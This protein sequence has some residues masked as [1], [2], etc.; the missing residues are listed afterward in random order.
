MTFNEMLQDI[1]NKDYE[2]IV[3]LAKSAMANISENLKGSVDDDGIATLIYGALGATMVVDG[4]FSSL[5]QK[6][7]SDMGLD[8]DGMFN[9]LQ[10][11]SKDEA[12]LDSFDKMVDSCNQETK[13]AMLVLVCAI[14]AI[15]ER[16][17]VEETGLIRKLLA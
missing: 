17:S 3:D 2:E 8:V 12:Y 9:F 6:F 4:S 10:S 7:I 16:I 15:D 14:A 5:E 1:V 13:S 11:I